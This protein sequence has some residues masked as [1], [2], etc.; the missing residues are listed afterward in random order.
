MDIDTFQREEEFTS[1][2]DEECL[3]ANPF[4]KGMDIRTKEW[5]EYQFHWHRI[6]Y[7]FA[8]MSHLGG[9]FLVDEIEEIRW[10]EEMFEKLV[11]PATHKKVA[12]ASIRH[13]TSSTDMDFVPGKGSSPRTS[14]GS[15]G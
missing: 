2:T 4:V 11:L 3:L 15:I 13:R 6:F 8:N 12:L 14:C 9:E 1:M 7:C 10:I 5:S